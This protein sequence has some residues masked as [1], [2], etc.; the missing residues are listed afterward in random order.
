MFGGKGGAN[1][2]ELM[3]MIFQQILVRNRLVRMTQC[4]GNK[5]EILRVSSILLS[6]DVYWSRLKS[7]QTNQP[8]IMHVRMRDMVSYARKCK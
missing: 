2:K 4:N 1:E 8:T 5:F 3:N 7:K 6:S